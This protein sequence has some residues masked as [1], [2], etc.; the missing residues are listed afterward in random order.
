[1]QSNSTSTPNMRDIFGQG[2][3]MGSLDGIK[4]YV[5]NLLLFDDENT[6]APDTMPFWFR[7]ARVSEQI[8]PQYDSAAP[9]G[10][11]HNYKTYNS[12]GSA[13]YRFEI[14]WNALMMLKEIGQSRNQ[15]ASEGAISGQ[16]TREGSASDLAMVSRVIEEDR[17]WLEALAYPSQTNAGLI[18]S[19]PPACILVIPGI[20]TMRC[21]LTSLSFEFEDS[22]VRGLIKQLRATTVWEEAPEGRIT[23]EDQ[24]TGGS[25]RTWG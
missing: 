16:V 13:M 20:V 2:S 21:L 4:G 24:L 11:S 5:R 6:I 14:Y 15:Q 3:P 8:T 19:S 7:P 9:I 12:T 17:R 10:M 18:G 25:F 22:D 1:M 23:M